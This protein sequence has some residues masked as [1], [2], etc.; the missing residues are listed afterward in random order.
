MLTGD[1]RELLQRA[2]VAR[3][4]TAARTGRPHVN[5]LYFVIADDHVHRQHQRHARRF[6][7]ADQRARQRELVLFDQAL[8]HVVALRRLAI[9][10]RHRGP[11][12]QR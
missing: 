11:L 6:G 10:D 2:M 9:D 12:A 4:A 7:L 8:L 5:P 1:A 3:I